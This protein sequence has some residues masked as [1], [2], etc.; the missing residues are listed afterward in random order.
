MKRFAIAA[1]S[2]LA[3]VVV[4][5]ALMLATQS[6]SSERGT[7]ASAPTA[8]VPGATPT[9]Q[10]EPVP[11]ITRVAPPVSDQV[12]VVW[13]PG[14][15]PEAFADRLAA[16][17][18]VTAV[19]TVRSDLVHL[20]ESQGADGEIVDKPADGMVIPLEM[21]AFDPAT[22]PAF[23]PRQDSNA[24]ANLAVGQVILGS[25]SAQLRR[26][27]PGA[28]LTFE[29]GSS[30]TVAAVVDDV[31]I[32][33]AEAALQV[34][35]ADVVGVAVER[36]LLI[37]YSGERG[38][39][40]GSI[41]EELPA[42]LAVRIRAPGETPVLRHGDAVLPQ[43]FIKEQFGEFA[44]RPGEDLT[45]ELEAEWVDA[46]IVTSQVPMLGEVKCH[47]ILLPSLMGAMEEIE[48]RNL[49]FLID[50][51]GF[52][53]CFNPRYIAN[54]KGISRHAWGA[55]VDINIGS[56]PE[57]L[58]SIQDPRLIEIMEQWGF[59][60]GDDWLIPDPGHFE[61]LRPAP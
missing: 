7:T 26:L 10:D 20:A 3:G 51:D 57:G 16:L 38:E 41:R 59:T 11:S 37:R 24:F 47:R 28:V 48:R 45:F 52:L 19:T 42:G 54:G 44:Y 21:M 36:Y 35:E 40:E 23:L 4:G 17:P 22:Y 27:G 43:V 34:T 55:A 50:P 60:S 29:D 46:N 53:G 33:A 18:G 58:E 39:L 13:T 6:L 12:L 32:G 31:L 30:L 2:L 49:G 8:T 61:Y 25:T 56:N 5:A 14:G 1:V 9:T 15:L